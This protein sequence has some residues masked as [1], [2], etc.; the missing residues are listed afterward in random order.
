MK[1]QTS[2]NEKL[3]RYNLK[4]KFFPNDVIKET[5]FS[6][7][8]FNPHKL[9]AIPKISYGTV[10]DPSV[11]KFVR[12]FELTKEGKEKTK[13][14]VRNDSKKRAMDKATEICFANNWQYFITLTLDEE[15][16][17]RYSPTEIYKKLKNFLDNAVRR[18]NIKYIIFPEYH[19]Q[20]AYEEKPAIH[21]HGLLIAEKEVLNLEDSGKKTE[22]N[23]T[24]YNWN[25][26][27]YGFSTLI[28]LDGNCAVY[29]YVKKYM[30]KEN[31]KIF[32]KMYLS[33][34]KDL[35]REVPTEYHNVDYYSFD[36]KE[37]NIP[38]ALLSVKYKTL[39]LEGVEN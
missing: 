20:H 15:K 4:I 9:E 21:L 30:T 37:Y 12:Y 19:K 31:E 35:I 5:C 24:I 22:Q 16:I 6:R 28:E 8:I 38:S 23:Q 1:N 33:G 29:D 7:P 3:S 17:N 18:K 39:K 36:G 34:G 27:K 26:W 13:E 25:D 32:G 10:Y 11:D 2:K 14:R